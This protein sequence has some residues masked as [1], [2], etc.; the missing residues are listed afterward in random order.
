VAL[1]ATRKAMAR[2]DQLSRREGLAYRIYLI[3]LVQDILRNTH[4]GTLATLNSVSAKP[5][6]PTAG[7][8]AESPA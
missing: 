1:E 6:L 7:L 4:G 2:L 8:F 5:A 3:M